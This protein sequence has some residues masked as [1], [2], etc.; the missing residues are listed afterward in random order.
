MP[1]DESGFSNLGRGGTEET[2]AEFAELGVIAPA[3]LQM[4]PA[5]SPSDLGVLDSL[6][7]AVGRRLNQIGFVWYARLS[8]AARSPSADA[9]L[10]L[11]V[12]CG[13][14]FSNWNSVRS[15]A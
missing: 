10:R 15:P 14:P 3:G 4:A 2:Q 12:P 7:F 13:R 6:G 11:P 9:D 1:A 5:N 8:L